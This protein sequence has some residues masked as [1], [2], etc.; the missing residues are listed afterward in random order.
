MVY[1][2]PGIA[3][4]IEIDIETKSMQSIIAV[5]DTHCNVHKKYLS[6]VIKTEA[7]YLDN[8]REYFLYLYMALYKQ[9]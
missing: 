9:W 3:T 5:N 8:K 2:C 1:F 6:I 7:Q 4:T